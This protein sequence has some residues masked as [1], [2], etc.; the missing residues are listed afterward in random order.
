MMIL[1]LSPPVALTVLAIAVFGGMAY[2]DDRYKASLHSITF[3]MDWAFYVAIA[4]SGLDFLAALVFLFAGCCCK[5]DHE[6]Y[7]QGNVM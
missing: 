7:E 4:A 5:S 3:N 1:L 6:G 2:A